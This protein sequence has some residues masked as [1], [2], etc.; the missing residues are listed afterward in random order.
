VDAAVLVVDALPT[1]LLPAEP[2]LERA[3]A[4][5]AGQTASDPHAIVAGGFAGTSHRRH[6]CPAPFEGEDQ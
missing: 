4:I 1:G 2:T 6:R 5:V 3:R